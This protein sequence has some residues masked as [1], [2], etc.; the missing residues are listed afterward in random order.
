MSVEEMQAKLNKRGWH[1]FEASASIGN[2]VFDTLKLVIKLVLDKAK[3]S[4]SN[5]NV[6]V[7]S[8][9]AEQTPEQSTPQPEVQPS[10]GPKVEGYTQDVPQAPISP[11]Q[12]QP[13]AASYATGSNT[14][15]QTS[16]AT[17]PNPQI[18]TDQTDLANR[19]FP[20]TTQGIK[21]NKTAQ[22]GYK[23]V[24]SEISDQAL[25]KNVVMESE[26]SENSDRP[27]MAPSLRKSNKKKRGFFKRLFGIK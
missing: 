27:L 20:G 24:Q 19:P 2:G 9:V 6:P 13:M 14:Q 5:A 11:P 4:G 16:T 12:E 8:S 1:Y 10:S 3:N 23:S 17:V 22:P 7:Q 26:S 18:Q 15:A 25:E 21:I